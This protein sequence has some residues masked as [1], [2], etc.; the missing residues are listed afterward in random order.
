MKNGAPKYKFE[1]MFG[2]VEIQSRIRREGYIHIGEGR[3]I[4]R[5]GNGE[6]TQITEWEPTGLRMTTE[7]ARRWW[8]IW[9]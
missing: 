3:S 6:I 1:C 5:D 2:T 7:P 8:E 4:R 9:K